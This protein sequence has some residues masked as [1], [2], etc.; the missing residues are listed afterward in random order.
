MGSQA[1]PANVSFSG[2]PSAVP[3]KAGIWF[4][5]EPFSG[6]NVTANSSSHLL[7]YMYELT[8]DFLLGDFF[9]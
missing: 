4:R 1:I 7:F 3:K 8:E 5:A 6:K 2:H 9:I